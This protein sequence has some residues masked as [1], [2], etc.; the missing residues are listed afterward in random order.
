M[1]LN[2]EGLTVRYRTPDGDVTALA[3]VSLSLA[4]RRTL[5]ARVEPLAQ[6][7]SHQVNS[8]HEQAHGKARR[9]GDPWRA[10]DELARL[11]DHQSP[12]GARRLGTEA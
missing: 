8:D 3:D 12:V 1:T 4:P 5:E 10:V 9:Q 6:P 11:G 7:V 2:I